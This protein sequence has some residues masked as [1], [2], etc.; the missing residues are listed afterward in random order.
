MSGKSSNQTLLY[1]GERPPVGPD[2]QHIAPS[3]A[4]GSEVFS[5]MACLSFVLADN[6]LMFSHLFGGFPFVVIIAAMHPPA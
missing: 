5:V 4:S 6:V 2:R 3:A 1:H